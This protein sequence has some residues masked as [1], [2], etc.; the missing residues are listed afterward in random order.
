MWVGNPRKRIKMKFEDYLDIVEKEVDSFGDLVN[1]IKD[2]D[3][4]EIF[5]NEFKKMIN[6]MGLVLKDISNIRLD[7]VVFNLIKN[8]LEMVFS[9]EATNIRFEDNRTYTIDINL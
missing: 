7:N 3:V 4:E 5:E 1:G 8:K 9:F 2:K 6:H